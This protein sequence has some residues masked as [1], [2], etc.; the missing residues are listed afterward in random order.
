M[1]CLVLVRVFGVVDVELVVLSGRA[2]LWGSVRLGLHGR[3]LGVR[4]MLS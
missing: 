4:E 1:V 3:L 2:S